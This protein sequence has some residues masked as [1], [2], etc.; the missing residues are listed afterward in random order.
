MSP[1]QID[2]IVEKPAWR[3]HRGTGKLVVKQLPLRGPLASLINTRTG[4]DEQVIV[5]NAYGAYSWIK[6]EVVRKLVVQRLK[7]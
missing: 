4:A 3:S 5:E 1:S 6:A 7:A 2:F